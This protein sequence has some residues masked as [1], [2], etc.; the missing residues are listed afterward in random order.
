MEKSDSIAPFLLHFRAVTET[1]W[2]LAFVVFEVFA[3][4]TTA[5]VGFCLTAASLVDLCQHRTRVKVKPRSWQVLCPKTTP[6]HLPGESRFCINNF[7]LAWKKWMR[8][9]RH[10][11][12]EPSEVPSVAT[13]KRGLSKS[14]LMV[15]GLEWRIKWN[16]STSHAAKCE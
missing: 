13:H 3:T 10:A 14:L 7:A 12:M 5:Q 16:K 15:Q 1:W 2:C 11:L 4:S 9:R 6:F 8:E